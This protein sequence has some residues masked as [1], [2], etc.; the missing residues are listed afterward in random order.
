MGPE[1]G[2]RFGYS[3]GFRATQ[4]M[5]TELVPRAKA[6]DGA[7]NIFWPVRGHIAYPARSLGGQK[8]ADQLRGGGFAAAPRH[9]NEP[10][11]AKNMAIQTG[12]PDFDGIPAKANMCSYSMVGE[13]HVPTEV[14]KKFAAVMYALRAIKEPGL[15]LPGLS[16]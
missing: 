1:H 13:F 12:Q 8:G 14:T 3:L 2:H 16:L 15:L 5:D 9:P 7:G 10:G 6:K 11:P 4:F